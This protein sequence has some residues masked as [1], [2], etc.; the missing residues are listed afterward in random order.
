MDGWRAASTSSC[1]GTGHQRK[2]AERQAARR[3][4]W[5]Q[6]LPCSA[7]QGRWGLVGG[8]SQ[9]LH[10]RRWWCLSPCPWRGVG[11]CAL[12]TAISPTSSAPGPSWWRWSGNRSPSTSD[13]CA[14]NHRQ[15]ES[16]NFHRTT[17]T[18]K[19]YQWCS[20]WMLNPPSESFS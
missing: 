4:A 16:L 9:P 18:P 6:R 8:M 14:V 5:N 2:T 1:P 3:R 17:V 7:H 12:P 20:L 11:T 19:G 10:L 13:D 15:P